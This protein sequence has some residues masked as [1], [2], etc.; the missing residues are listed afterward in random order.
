M[1]QRRRGGGIRRHCLSKGPENGRACHWP[2]GSTMTPGGSQHKSAERKWA[3]QWP[4]RPCGRTVPFLRVVTGRVIAQPLHFGEWTT[5]NTPASEGWAAAS[6]V[7]P[8]GGGAGPVSVCDPPPPPS[9]GEIIVWRPKFFF[10]H[11]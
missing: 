7:W 10:L 9:F 5:A 6:A 2:T 4:I 1:R 3:R 8:Q 11:A